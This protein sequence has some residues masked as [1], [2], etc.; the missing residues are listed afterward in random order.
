MVELLLKLNA[1]GARFAEIPLQL[2]YDQKP[3]ATKM[4][5][6]NNMRRLLVLLVRWRLRGFDEVLL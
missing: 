6:G 2:R 3:T 5:V 4:R 1:L